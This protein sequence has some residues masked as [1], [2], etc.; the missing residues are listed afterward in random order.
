MFTHLSRK[1]RPACGDT[2]MSGVTLATPAI[3]LRAA[4]ISEREITGRLYFCESALRGT[5]GSEDPHRQLLVRRILCGA[6]SSS[7]SAGSSDP[8]TRGPG[9]LQ[10]LPDHQHQNVMRRE[11]ALIDR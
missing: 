3:R 8:A 4:R 9:S 10:P 11:A 1:G 5:G 6:P 2:S 7:C